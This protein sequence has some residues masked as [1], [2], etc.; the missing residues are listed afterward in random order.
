MTEVV[1]NKFVFYR[2]TDLCILYGMEQLI[3]LFEKFK[4]IAVY[5]VELVDS[6]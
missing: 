2:I 6:S 5:E 4:G 3:Y 1:N